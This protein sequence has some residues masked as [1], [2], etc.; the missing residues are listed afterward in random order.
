MG[1]K[2][3]AAKQL[4]ASGAFN[5]LTSFSQFEKRK[6]KFPNSK[7]VGDY[8]EILVEGILYTHPEFNAKEVWEVGHVPARIVKKLNLPKHSSM[9]IDGVYE[10]QS[11]NIIPY[12][13]KNYSS[14]LTVEEVATFL[15]VTEKSLKDRV[16]FTNV[17]TVAKE[18]TRRT[19]VR[20]VG[21]AFF[22][23]LTKE[24]FK[25]FRDWLNEKPVKYQKR[26]PRPHQ[27]E[28]INKSVRELKKN[29]RAQVVLPC[30]TGKTL[31]A[32]WT[33]TRLDKEGMLPS[34][35]VMVLVPSLS[36]VQQ[37]RKD[38][39]REMREDML[40]MC[41]CSDPSVAKNNDD[42]LGNDPK[43]MPFPVVTDYTVI[44]KFLRHKTGRLK[45]IF[46]TY[47]S[48][49]VVAR[50]LDCRGVK[51]L[52]L[53]V[54]DEAHRTAG[55]SQ[56]G[57]TLHDKNIKVRKRLF[58]TAT[59]KHYKISK[60]RLK[61]MGD[62]M[63]VLSMDDPKVYGRV[64][65]R[66]SFKEAVDRGIIVPLKVVV[67]LITD[68]MIA[69]FM[70]EKAY[71]NVKGEN[72]DLRWAAAQIAHAQA[73]KKFG[74]KKSISYLSRISQARDYAE[75][76]TRS[77][78]NYLRRG[79][80]A[81]HVSSQQNS[82]ERAN[83]LK[84]FAEAP[85]A[86]IS[87]ARCL[88][89]GV[90]LPSVDMVAF[91]HPR[92]SHVDIV[93]AIGRPMR[94]APGK[95]CGYVLIPLHVQQGKGETFEEAVERTSQDGLIDIINAV[96]EHDEDLTAIIQAMRQKIGEGKPY[97]PRILKDKIEFLGPRVKLTT[98]KNAITTTMIS[99]LTSPWDESY[100]RVVAY[101]KKHGKGTFP[102]RGEKGYERLGIWITDQR[103]K[104]KT[105]RLPQYR[106]DLLNSINM[107]WNPID[108]AW[109]LG[110]ELTKKYGVVPRNF[111]VPKKDL[112]KFANLHL[113]K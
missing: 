20:L 21:G 67:S 1:S 22:N 26:K 61:K 24:D 92:R 31:S 73:R 6:E 81:Y 74:I 105:G 63:Q 103:L 46:S 77:L 82:G 89:E 8:L 60:K 43:E 98:L 37:T 93:Q 49:P 109:Q 30:G 75:H 5:R 100:G 35:T 110:F 34:N 76:P 51:P 101:Q 10:D 80:E 16:L 4:I 91:I 69:D 12:Q 33:V 11:G 3:S 39:L 94:T 56:F 88:T 47:H 71:T 96:R 90:D 99:K 36:L 44:R 78:K 59:P 54:Y 15:G 112:E 107:E 106:I 97:N 53:I 18:I 45:V 41:V 28:F 86:D 68:Q 58:M 108:A 38:W 32:L 83:I 27:K 57:F 40:D 42:I 95:K 19:G 104:Y 70:N 113:R 66:M 72:I 62:D 23:S 48:A 29:D 111:V 84:E 65:Y 25:A 50:A 79:F 13:V 2:H 102:H 17:P 55:N 14:A 64:A 52:D 7:M 9:G 87:N 85:Y